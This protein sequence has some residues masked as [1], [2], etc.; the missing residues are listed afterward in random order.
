MKIYRCGSCACQS[1]EIG[2]VRFHVRSHT[3]K[4]E[5]EKPILKH[6]VGKALT[7]LP[8]QK[9]GLYRC[10]VCS[11]IFDSQNNCLEHVKKYYNQQIAP[12]KKLQ[13]VL[14]KMLMKTRQMWKTKWKTWTF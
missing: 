13:M 12:I 6:R 14:R 8:Q 10:E 7:P 1:K 11:N 5:P 9:I 3:N 4:K 2:H